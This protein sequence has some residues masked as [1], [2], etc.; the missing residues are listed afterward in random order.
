MRISKSLSLL[1]NKIVY[2]ALLGLFVRLLGVS[3]VYSLPLLYLLYFLY[4]RVPSLFIYTGFL[5][6][7]MLIS[8]SFI[9]LEPNS[10]KAVYV[11]GDIKTTD[12]TS[13]TAVQNGLVFKVYTDQVVN[14]VPGDKVMI[15][16]DMQEMIN[17]TIPHTFNY[18]NYLLSKRKGRFLCVMALFFF[19]KFASS[20]VLKIFKSYT[21]L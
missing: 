18:K 21:R 16:G 7:L 11:K 14:L 17:Q 19:C 3:L 9:I 12:I 6:V 13:F 4:R 10:L 8:T 15:E 20:K 1:R 2:L 5:L